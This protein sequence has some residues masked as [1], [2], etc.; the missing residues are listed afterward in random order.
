[1][2]ELIIIGKKAKLASAQ[3]AHLNSDL[4]NRVLLR[5][6]D[7]LEEDAGVLLKANVAELEQANKMD[8]KGAMVERLTLSDEKIAGIAEGLREI[9]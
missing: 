3:L 1:M 9:A 7:L 4:K 2:D 5:V 8:L 6:A